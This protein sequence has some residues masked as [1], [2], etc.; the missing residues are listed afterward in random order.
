MK[1]FNNLITQ[2]QINKKKIDKSIHQVL[3][4]GNFIMGKEVITLENKLKKFTKSKYCITVSSGTDAL[5]I[6]L[7]S[8]NI[9]PGDEVITTS[10]SWISTAEVII[11]LGAKPVFVDV[12]HDTGLINEHLVKKM[13]NKKTK[14]VIVVS[15]FGQIPNIDYINSI[16]NKRGIPVIEDA[17]QSFGSKHKKKYSCNLTTIGC[18][19]FFPT[20]NLGC[21]GDGGAIFTN[22]DK[23]HRACR[24]IRLNGKNDNGNFVKIGV[25]GRLDTLQASILIAKLKSFKKEL[26]LRKNFA[27]KYIDAFNIST[28]KIKIIGLN[29]FNSNSWPTF[30]ILTKNRDKM[31]NFLEKNNILTKIY[32]IKPM[33]LYSPYRK[34]KKTTID[35]AK[36]ISKNILSL[37]FGPY[38]NY[39]YQNKVIK[40]IKKYTKKYE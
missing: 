3:G 21:Y 8:L 1:K 35:G 33:P 12:D 9:K 31:K 14:A 26:K 30:N 32:Y 24:L 37:P 16:C 29:K 27:L 7:M 19:S 10:F 6:S 34:F 40:L 13:I 4:H 11:N 38:L 18:T 17:A 25:Q 23:I 5:L 39:E 20:K 15:L 2:Y 28:S 36:N 22:S